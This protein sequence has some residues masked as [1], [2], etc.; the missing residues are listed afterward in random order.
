MAKVKTARR[1]ATVGYKLAITLAQKIATGTAS[2]CFHIEEELR[3][4]VPHQNIVAEYL[5]RIRLLADPEAEAGFSA[6]LTEFIASG[7]YGCFPSN[8]EGYYGKIVR[9]MARSDAARADKKL[10]TFLTTMS[11]ACRRTSK[12]KRAEVAELYRPGP[13]TDPQAS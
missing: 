10:V 11:K 4:G 3:E 9:Q 13:A 5:D 7:L 1:G 6:M 8:V 12:K 2:G